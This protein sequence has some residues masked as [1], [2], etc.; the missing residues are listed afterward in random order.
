M[1]VVLKAKEE[2]T[3]IQMSGSYYGEWSA[4]RGKDMCEVKVVFT[5]KTKS[6]EFKKRTDKIPKD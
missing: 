5:K 4:I 3:T 1:F 6:S 2:M